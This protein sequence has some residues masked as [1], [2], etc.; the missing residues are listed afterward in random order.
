[1]IFPFLVATRCFLL[2]CRLVF[3]F[4]GRD[5]RMR[6]SPHHC[7][8][9]PGLKHVPSALEGMVCL[10]SRIRR[11]LVCHYVGRMLMM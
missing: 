5:G 1:M 6:F 2:Y 7:R 10:V 9:H 8:I 4:G 11:G 3:E